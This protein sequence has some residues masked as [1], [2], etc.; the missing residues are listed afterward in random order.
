MDDK[1][2]NYLLGLKEKWEKDI[3][4]YKS[5]LSNNSIN[6]YGEYGAK[7]YIEMAQKNI[8]DIELK[9]GQ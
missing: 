2:R 7:E 6:I 5:Y 4:K 3:L 9:L 1:Y 8:E